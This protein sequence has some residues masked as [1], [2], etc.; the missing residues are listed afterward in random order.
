MLIKS[1]ISDILLL[2]LRKHHERVDRTNVRA[3]RMRRSEEKCCL[4]HYDSHATALMDSQPLLLTVW[5]LYK[6]SRIAV[7]VWIWEELPRPYPQMRSY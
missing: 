5:D 2:R 1:D 4:L 3:Q 6:I 7:C